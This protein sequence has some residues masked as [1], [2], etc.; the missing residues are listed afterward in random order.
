MSAVQDESPSGRVGAGKVITVLGNFSGRNAGDNAI[1]GNLVDDLRSAYPGL[2]FL[3]PTLN[4]S[5]VRRTFADREIRAL[6]LMPWNGS[7]KIFGIP[8]LYSML[9]ADVV[10]VTDNILFDRKF[11]NPAFNYLS[12]IALIAPLC[13]RRG[14]PIVPYNASI[15][16]INTERG[17]SALQR[18]LDASPTIILRDRGSKELLER[19]GVRCPEIIL[20]ADCAVNTTPP[21]PAELDDVFRRLGLADSNRRRIGVNINVYIDAWQKGR[22]GREQFVALVGNVV[23]RLTRELDVDVVFFVTQV[24]DRHITEELQRAVGQDTRAVV[25]TNP[26]F[27]YKEIAG[28]LS[29]LELLI[30]MRTHALILSCAVGTPVININA[31]PKS[32]GFLETLCMQDWSIDF[33]ELSET[34][35]YQ[36]AMRAW[37]GRSETR[38]ALVAAVQREKAK[39]LASVKAVGGILGIEASD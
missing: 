25:V 6:S 33:E 14:V 11:Y 16:P 13:R 24:M 12:T 10:L 20:G 37:E 19:L 8:T 27:D 4:A 17:T 21:S 22:F 23:R 38:A 36:M 35:L 29:R 28:I 39:A 9:K 26:E 30:G 2:A 15:G 32:R 3:V 34:S 18:V 1:L 31:Y 5:F 7:L